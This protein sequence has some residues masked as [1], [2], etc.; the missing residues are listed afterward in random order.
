MTMT[1]LTHGATSAWRASTRWWNNHPHA[2]PLLLA[3]F[4]VL[5]AARCA[6]DYVTGA[7]DWAAIGAVCAGLAVMAAVFEVFRVQFRMHLGRK[8]AGRGA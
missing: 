2:L 1:T 4:A 7:R 6:Y 8:S 3:G 5:F